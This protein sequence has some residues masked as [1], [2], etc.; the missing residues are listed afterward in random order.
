MKKLFYISGCKA[1]NYALDFIEK[2]NIIVDK[3]NL[4][5]KPITE[6]DLL[7]MEALLPGGMIELV[8][9]NSEYLKELGYD[10]RTLNKKELMYVIITNPMI[11]SYPILLE[12]TNNKNPIKLVIG[13]NPIEW[14]IFKDEPTSDRYYS[15]I[16]KFYKF[17]TCCFFDETKNRK[18]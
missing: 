15:N 12:T 8:N 11:L 5:Y 18:I 13:F 14:N 4:T 10:I 1:S 9:L 7:D 3:S 17:S 16:N 6:K 2:N